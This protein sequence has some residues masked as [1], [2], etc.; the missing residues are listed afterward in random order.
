MD[1]EQQRSMIHDDLLGGIET[2]ATECRVVR[3]SLFAGMA[4]AVGRRSVELPWEGGSAA[5]LRTRLAAE[6][7]TLAPLL[8]RSAVAIGD[9][10]VADD[11]AVP[12]DANVAI[13]PP[14]SGG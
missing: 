10:Y 4:A 9:T 7:P 1:R 6:F 2:N 13:I 14:V 12:F 3:V 11:A 8:A 5:A